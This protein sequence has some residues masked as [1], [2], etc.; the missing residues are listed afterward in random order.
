MCYDGNMSYWQK[1]YLF[2]KKKG[3]SEK[4]GTNSS[5]IIQCSKIEIIYSK[6]IDGCFGTTY[7]A[8]LIFLI[9]PLNITPWKGRTTNQ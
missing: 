2:L 7:R 3:F 5:I 8:W 6:G 1:S 9:I 4:D